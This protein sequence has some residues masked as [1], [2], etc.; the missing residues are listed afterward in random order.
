[1]TLAL[2]ILTLIFLA[3]Q[4]GLIYYLWRRQS[5]TIL[6][7]WLIGAAI[8]MGVVTLIQLLPPTWS[9]TESINRSLLVWVGLFASTI[10]LSGVVLY[11]TLEADTTNTET[12]DTSDTATMRLKTCPYIPSL[13][14]GLV[15]FC[16]SACSCNLHLMVGYTGWIHFL[17]CPQGW[18]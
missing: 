10:A 18:V 15:V 6:W 5:Q 17:Y 4:G 16:C 9:L 1:M 3:A 12:E 14:F 11:D 8:T 2:Q 7:R 13:E